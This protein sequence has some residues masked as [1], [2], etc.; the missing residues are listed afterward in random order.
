MVGASPG[1]KRGRRTAYAF[2]KRFYNRY[3]ATC[4]GAD[5]KG[6]EPDFPSLID[7]K[8]RMKQL[9]VLDK[10]AKGG[11]KMPAFANILERNKEEII[12]YLF[13][14]Q[15]GKMIEAETQK[16]DST[17]GYR[18]ITA[19]GHFRDAAGR[20]AIKPPW[21]TLNA[22]DLNTGEYAWRI[23]LGNYPELQAD[24]EPMTGTENWGGPMVTA[25]GLVFIGATRDKKFRAFH[26]KT[27]ILLWETDLPGGG[28]AT[29]ATYASGGRQFVTISVSASEDNPAGQI[30]AFAIPD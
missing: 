1:K 14:I 26:K 19:Y 9:E 30:M 15:D 25:G 21:G 3:C 18:N 13:E 10:I 20:P 28:Y 16:D 24:G 11:G 5:R 27:G 7:L 17:A 6:L 12:A 4:H 22:I 23:P 8:N 29:P 2:G